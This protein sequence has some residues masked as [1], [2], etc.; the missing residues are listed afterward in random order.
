[1]IIWWLPAAVV[2]AELAAA[3]VGLEVFLL[4]Q[5]FLLVL[6]LHIQLRLVLLALEAQDLLVAT[7]IMVLMVHFL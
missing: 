7:E 5:V 2:A 4:L 1:L 3:A 6:Q